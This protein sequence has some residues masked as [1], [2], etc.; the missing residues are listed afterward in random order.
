MLLGQETG[1]EFVES[2]TVVKNDGI[3]P[4]EPVSGPEEATDL[5]TGGSFSVLVSLLKTNHRKGV[6]LTLHGVWTSHQHKLG[7]APAH[8]SIEIEML[9]LADACIHLPFANILVFKRKD[10]KKANSKEQVK[11]Q[12]TVCVHCTL[13]KL[14]DF[15]QLFRGAV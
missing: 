14:N 7:K 10:L 2:P 1:V 8:E 5:A 13:S 15:L 11:Q 12:I 9:S 3:Y 6:F 4:S